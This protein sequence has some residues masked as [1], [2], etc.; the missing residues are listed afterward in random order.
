MNILSKDHQK[1]TIDDWKT[2]DRDF[3]TDLINQVKWYDTKLVKYAH[4]PNIRKK[5]F[6]V[7]SN[8]KTLIRKEMKEYSENYGEAYSLTS[9]RPTKAA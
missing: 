4:N 9:E 6:E 1:E 5:M 3:I 2:E 7:Q 8:L